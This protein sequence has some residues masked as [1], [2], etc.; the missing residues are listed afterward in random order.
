MDT[1]DLFKMAGLSTS[2]VALILIAYRVLKSVMGKR[3]VSSCCGKKM[4]I[5]VDIQPMTP[6]EEP[7]VVNVLN[8]MMQKK[9]NME[10]KSPLPTENGRSTEAS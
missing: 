2:G 3:L 10:I 6:K 9:N 7:V 5:G 1:T 4:D 8:P